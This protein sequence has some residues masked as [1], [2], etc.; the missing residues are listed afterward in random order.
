MKLVFT[1][2]DGI[3]LSG[4]FPSGTPVFLCKQG[5]K[6]AF[7]VEGPVSCLIISSNNPKKKGFRKAI[8]KADSSYPRIVLRYVIEKI[9]KEYSNYGINHYL[10]CLLQV[11]AERCGLP[12]LESFPMWVK[13]T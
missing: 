8:I 6:R 10:S 3:W 2:N 13:V 9:G 11:F 5:I 1:N 4:A 12:D 7:L